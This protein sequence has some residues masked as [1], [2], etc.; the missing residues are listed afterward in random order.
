MSE[1]RRF[2]ELHLDVDS[3][4]RSSA[5]TVFH[6]LTTPAPHLTS[7][8][9]ITDGRDIM[10][11]ALPHMFDGQLQSLRKLCLRHLTSW[12]RGYF[13]NLTHICLYDQNPSTLPSMDEFLNFL[14]SSPLLEELAL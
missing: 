13:Q 12:P 14:E 7:L 9:L 4:G 3:R 2:K 6:R 8:T 11:G 10:N 1:S 5:A